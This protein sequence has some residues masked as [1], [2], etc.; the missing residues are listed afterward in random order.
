MLA[1]IYEAFTRIEKDKFRKLLIH[2]RKACRLAFGL[3]VTQ[4]MPKKI[5][6]KHFEGLIK[7][8]K[9]ST[10]RLEA[11][12]MFKTLDTN[13]S[14]FI[15]L[16]EFYDV[17]DVFELKWEL[18]SIGTEWFSAIDN[19]WCKTFL[20]FVHKLVVHKWF[21]IF[22]YIMIGASAV[23]QIIE[24]IFINSSKEIKRKIEFIESTP[25]SLIFVTL[26]GVEASLKLI[27][28]GLIQYF[29]SFWNRFDFFITCLA[30]IGLMFAGAMSL[31]F[32]FIFVLRSIRLL[33]LLEKKRRF[34]DIMGAF[35]FIIVKRF[36]SLSIV[37][38]I[39]YYIFAI[40][41]MELFSAYDLKNC[42]KNTSVEMLFAYSE[43]SAING[44]YYLN[45][46]TDIIASYG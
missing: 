12:L 13:R 39:V 44:F 15:T 42:C 10:T 21:H 17:Y 31:P 9:P 45:N 3:L 5:S 25:L 26:Y 38:L 14:G 24:A 2:R 19:K 41:G 27:G 18:K 16:D 7:Y 37:V 29:K 22:V 8:Y 11:Y 43:T 4:K 40:L 32:A 23:Y 36:V 46:F 35:I 6:F 34:Q 20:R 1:V 33:K 30:I 28:L